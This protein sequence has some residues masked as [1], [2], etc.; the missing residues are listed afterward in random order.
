MGKKKKKERQLFVRLNVL[1]LVTFVL[2]SALIFRLGL[3]QIVQGEEYVQQTEHN[4]QRTIE[5]T[6]PRGFFLDRHYREIV[7][8]EHMY[9]L[10][11]TR[12]RELENQKEEIATKLSNL[13]E[14]DAEEILAKM[15]EGVFLT[16]QRIKSNLTPE[17]MARVAEHLDQLPGV[18]I[19]VDSERNYVYEGLLDKILGSDGSITPE[20]RDYYLSRGYRLNEKVGRSGLELQYEEQLRGVPSESIITV[21]RTQRIIDHPIEIPGRRGNDLVLTIDVEFQQAIEEVIAKEIETNP[22]IPNDK[23]HEQP[24]FVALNP[25]TGEVLGMSNN[26]YTYKV[27][28]YYPGSTVKMATVL[29]GLHEGIVGPGTYINDRPITISGQTFR[30]WR[31]LGSVDAVKALQLSSNIYMIN[32]GMNMAGSYSTGAV[33]RAQDQLRDYYAQFGLGVPTGIDLPDEFAGRIYNSSNYHYPGF[34][35]QLTFGQL[36][37]YTPL[38]LAQ[39]VATIANGGYRMQPYLVKEI[40]RG[41]PEDDGIGEVIWRKEPQ[42]LN[43]IEMS[44]E[45][46]RIVQRG[47]EAV[48]G[49][50]GT[51][52]ST[53]GNFPVKVA[54]KTGTAQVRKGNTPW[55][56]TLLVGYAPADDP[57][58]AFATLVP[59]SQRA[60][61]QTQS[62]AQ[63]ITKEI[64]SVYFD[65][66]ENENDGE[67]DT[68]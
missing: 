58:I 12:Q 20:N 1:F 40:R 44:D 65:L 5:G 61:S 36:D 24:L 45:H 34:L 49:P 43:R 2:F 32:I 17:E 67:D 33:S 48:T 53:F 55:N 47:M 7:T 3:I 30:S 22:D 25:K 42:V 39:Y 27:G 60:Q 68:D 9:T 52:S 62:A 35:A 57:Q 59:Y 15:E 46:L 18:E 4:T 66:Q 41:S 19:I 38:Q 29:A 54:A 21:D 23:P 14:M 28:A 16:P 50:G 37:E 63:R 10:T 8:N 31:T 11:F 6:A 13:I 51:A 26:I 56:H 64:L